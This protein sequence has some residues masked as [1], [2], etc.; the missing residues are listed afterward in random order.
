MFLDDVESFHRFA[1]AF[2]AAMPSADRR[3]LGDGL[4]LAERPVDVGLDVGGGTG[5]ASVAFPRI[6]WTV[7]DAAEGM[8]RRAYRKGLQAVRADAAAL[9][10]RDGSVDAVLVVDALHHLPDART[11]LAEV[12]RVL[13]PGGVVVVREFDPGTW[14]G[15]ALA[16]AEHVGGFD[17][18]FYRPAALA[19]T[20]RHVGLEPHVPD[21]G[22][23]YT[24][25]GVKPG[26]R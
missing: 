22:F 3:A 2:D 21:R 12:E 26:D 19:G 20:M 11:V 25:A 8:L 7:V 13:A 5:R 17:S 16:A 10:V 1:W 9:P 15:R 6:D 23:E 18:T 24:V 14:R 4:S